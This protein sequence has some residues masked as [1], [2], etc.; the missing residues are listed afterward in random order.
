M[1]SRQRDEHGAVSTEMAV[2]MVTFLAGFLMLVVF[3]GRVAQAENDVRSAA[4]NAAR[5]ASL[6][7]DPTRADAE[8]RRVVASNLTSSG[9]TCSHGLDVVVN[10]D[11]FHPGGRVAVSVS[12]RAAFGDVATLAV[13]GTRTFNATATVVIDTYRADNR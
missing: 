1:T 3:A 9:L 10:V 8:A 12:C 2:I 13:P 11:Q 6:T 7:G 4:H 5:A